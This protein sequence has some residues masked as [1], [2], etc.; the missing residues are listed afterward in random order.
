MK[1]AFYPVISLQNKFT[2]MAMQVNM[3]PLA[4]STAVFKNLCPNCDFSETLTVF[5]PP[6]STEANINVRKI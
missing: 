2:M 3:L 1:E 4:Y 6:K 5:D